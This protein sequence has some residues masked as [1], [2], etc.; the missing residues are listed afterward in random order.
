VWFVC[1]S[2]GDVGVFFWFYTR[3]VQAVKTIE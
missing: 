2:R 1:L 3:V